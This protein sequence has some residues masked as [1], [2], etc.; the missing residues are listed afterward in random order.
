M[1]IVPVNLLTNERMTLEGEEPTE[2]LDIPPTPELEVS[3]PT[4]YRLRASMVSGSILVE[5]TVTTRIKAQCGRCLEMFEAEV[6]A[7]EVC[8]LYDDV[9][10]AELDVTDDIREDLLLGLPA[11][12]L[13]SDE[14]LGLCLKCGVN[15]NLKSCHCHKNTAEN[16][17]WGELDNL[18]FEK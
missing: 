9:T 16:L 2:F 18:K 14:C 6:K 5:G 15:R 1:I 11:N 10:T 4:Q 8:H 3:A 17:A 7:P 13:C 12:P